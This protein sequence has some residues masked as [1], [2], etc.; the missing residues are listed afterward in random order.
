[1]RTHRAA[2][3][4]AAEDRLTSIASSAFVPPGFV[5]VAA[6]VRAAAPS[7]A[8][9]A[10]LQWQGPRVLALCDGSIDLAPEV[11]NGIEAAARDAMLDAAAIPCGTSITTAVNVFLIED[12]ARVFLVDAGMGRFGGPTMG[13]L[14]ESLALAGLAPG[15]ITD[16]VLTHLH[17]DHCG[18]LIDAEGESLF[19]AARVHVVKIEHDHWCDPQ[20][21]AAA[22]DATRRFFDVALQTM[23]AVRDQL[24]LVAVDA[25]LSERIR[26]APA[27]GHTVGHVAVW[28]SPDAAR[29][30][31][32]CIW[33][34]I[35]HCA[36]LQIP[37]PGITVR[38]DSDPV[39]AERTR[40]DLLQAAVHRGFVV[41]GA[42]IPFPGLARIVAHGDSFAHR[43][44]NNN[45]DTA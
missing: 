5:G 32:L 25:Q 28:I 9:V 29:T 16:I 43:P 34:D 15:D 39:T 44:L 33:G 7:L 36:A 27:P 40:R 8:A 4:A 42:H 24:Q 23:S 10:S 30:P 19:R 18:G 6:A 41:A 12:G 38:F 20:R 17:R 11:F 37:S 2:P 26:L 13:W 1:M 22:S 3:R 31:P 35:V 45:G 21:A 14:V